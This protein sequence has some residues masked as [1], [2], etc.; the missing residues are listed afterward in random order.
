MRSNG[1]RQARRRSTGRS[2]SPPAS[3][4]SRAASSRP[5]TTSSSTSAA[6]TSRSAS[7][8]SR[9]STRTRPRA[10]SPTGSPR[11]GSIRSRAVTG[12]KESRR[13]RRSRA[14]RRRA[15]PASI[16]VDQR[17]RPD[18][19]LP[20]PPA[21][22]ER[23]AASA[24]RSSTSR[25]SGASRS[26]DTF[27]SP[28]FEVDVADDDT[29]RRMLLTT[30][31]VT[32]EA[33]RQAAGG[34]TGGTIEYRVQYTGVGDEV[35]ISPGGAAPGRS[36]SSTPRCSASWPSR[37]IE[38]GG[39]DLGRRA[40]RT[41]RR[42]R[43]Q[44]LRRAAG[45]AGRLVHGPPRRADR[46]HRPERRRQ[47]DAAADPRRLAASRAAA[48]CRSRRARS[49]GS[50]SSRRSTRS[51]RSPRTCACSRGSRSAP[52]CPPA[53]ERMLE[54]T[55]LRDR[56]GDEVGKLSG[57]NRQ[58]VNIAIGLLA[59]PSVLLLDEPT[60]SLDPRQ[61]EVLWA[62]VT[63]L[64][65]AGT[66]VVYAT[67]NVAEAERYADRV[68]VLA[69][70]E[71]LFSGSPRELEE[72]VGGAAAAPDF[73]SAF[74]RFLHEQGPLTMRWLLL[75]DLQILKRSPLLVARADR[76]L[77][78]RLAGGRRRALLRP[79]QAARRVRQPRA[80]GQVRGRAR[81]PPGR[82]HPVRGQA[83][84]EGRADPRQHARG[85]DR[86]GEVRRGARRARGPGRRD[87]ASSRARSG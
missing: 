2:P 52:T 22:A 45:A 14:R 85:G 16:D 64:A 58:R 86:E 37:R 74:V 15:T 23:P 44:G 6:P 65:E 42:G 63:G 54:Q 19:E 67:H 17:A 12:V 69:D 40:S 78:R 24:C 35:T 70:G 21:A 73:E 3:P 4:T 5:A 49:A 47:D 29:I 57:G 87:R 50:R 75:K 18:R 30:R 61:R 33:N 48:R 46:D 26:S 10:A 11:S 84:R 71:L 8:T 76:L 83:V 72:T 13:G 80:G 81:R 31:F 7:R 9:A 62:F 68:L 27:Q 55:G 60:S 82:R 59:E 36:R 77:G 28:R 34:I 38:V 25:P 32:P 79:G 20:P 43:Q 51:S 39:R 1:A 56:A 41:D 53:V 66:A